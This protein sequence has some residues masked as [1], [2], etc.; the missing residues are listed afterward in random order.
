M[1]RKNHLAQTSL[2]SV[3]DIFEVNK[4]AVLAERLLAKD[5]QGP[6]RLGP[7]AVTQKLAARVVGFEPGFVVRF[8]FE[9]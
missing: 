6:K 8:L 2:A 4:E 3:G 9:K 7:K 1:R 5:P